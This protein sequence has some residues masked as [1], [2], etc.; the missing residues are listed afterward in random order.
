[1]ADLQ[2]VRIDKDWTRDATLTATSAQSG[3]AAANAGNDNL[4][5]PWWGESGTETL[6]VTLD[7]SQA[8]SLIALHGTNADDGRTITVGGV[9]GVTLT[10]ERDVNGAP[11][12][13]VAVIDPPQTVSAVTFAIS[14]NAVNWSVAR[15]VVAEA[16]ALPNFLDGFTMEPHRPQYSD[17]NDF[18]HEIRYDLGIERWKGSG[19][20]VLTKAQMATLDAWWRSTKAGFHPTVIAPDPAQYPPLFARLTMGLPRKHDNKHLRVTVSFTGATYQELV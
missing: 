5:E 9:T 8:V 4:D 7:G 17:E 6:T 13:L 16:S 14:G 1:M 19:D 11:V 20:L 18:G 10:G 2:V 12:D 15:V 3:Y